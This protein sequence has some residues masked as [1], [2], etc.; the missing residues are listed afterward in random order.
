ME[1]ALK[2]KRNEL[3]EFFEDPG[4]GIRMNYY[5]PCPEPENVIGLNPH[6]D[7]G[8]LTILL[9]VN[10]VE[11]LQIRKD[12]MW[13]PIKPLSNAFV[14]NIGDMLE[15]IDNKDCSQYSYQIGNGSAA[16]ENNSFV[17]P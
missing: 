9:Q 15:V 14:I 17:P 16:A 10:E 12:G 6:S 7:S 2:M 1:K 13:I 8:A 5:P 4:Q 3:L 11:G